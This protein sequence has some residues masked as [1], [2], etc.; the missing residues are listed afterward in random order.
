MEQRVIQRTEELQAANKELEAFTY[1]VSH[2]LRAPL[3]HIS[4]FCRSLVA[5][6]LIDRF[7]LV[8][9]PIA[10]GQGQPLFS[11]LVEPLPLKLEAGKAFP[12][13]GMAQIY[14]PA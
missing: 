7:I 2:D 11:D 8:V 9:H 3:R 4:G 13:G 6:G 12:G 10:L 14:R 5:T 1:S